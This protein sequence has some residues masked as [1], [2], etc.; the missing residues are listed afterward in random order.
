M[1]IRTFF[2][3]CLLAV[4]ACSE[5]G[6]QPQSEVKNSQFADVTG[7]TVSGD[8]QA[9][10]FSVTISS[11]DTGCGQYAD[12][13]EVITGDGDLIYRRILLH[14]H[15]NE[16][17][18]TRSGGPVEISA[19]QTVTVRGHMNNNGYGGLVF[20]GSVTEGFAQT[21]LP[22]DFAAGLAETP[23]LPDGCAL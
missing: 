20:Q 12:W 21:E 22:K 17:P 18:F 15:V 8:E 23:P 3:I 4:T 2:V 19:G 11:P 13:W 14:S 5:S 16:Q 1:N 6:G 9:Y 10:T 7:V